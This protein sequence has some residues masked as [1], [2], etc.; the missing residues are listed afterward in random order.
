MILANIVYYCYNVMHQTGNNTLLIHFLWTNFFN[1]KV[2]LWKVIKQE[3]T[4]KQWK[5]IKT[6]EANM[7][8]NSALKFCNPGIP[9][10]HKAVSM[11]CKGFYS[12]SYLANELEHRNHATPWTKNTHWTNVASIFWELTRMIILTNSKRIPHLYRNEN[13]AG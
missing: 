7:T 3:Q 1:K 4:E 13:P 12:N 2:K 5:Q 10:S 11:Y 8:N 9:S 6:L